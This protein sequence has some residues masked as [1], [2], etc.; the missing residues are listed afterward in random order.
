MS[1]RAEDKQVFEM[2]WKAWYA[3]MVKRINECVMPTLIRNHLM[4]TV[5]ALLRNRRR[6]YLIA[7]PNTGKKMRLQ[8]IADVQKHARLFE[9]LK[10][11]EG[12]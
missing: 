2:M 8:L 9:Q 3:E 1:L 6:D 4:C 5:K 12:F 10:T 7:H 11:K